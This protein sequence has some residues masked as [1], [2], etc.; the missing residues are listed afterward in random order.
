MQ[1]KV[2]VIKEN[3]KR[4]ILM[5][6]KKELIAYLKQQ[7]IEIG[8]LAKKLKIEQEKLE[9]NNTYELE[10]EEFC[11]ICSYLNLD[12]WQFYNRKNKEENKK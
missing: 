6:V 8:Q 9:E 5:G 2:L 4:K 12:P 7:N 10:A 1:Q 3:K 11:E